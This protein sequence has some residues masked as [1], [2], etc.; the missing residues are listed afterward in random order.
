ML[1]ALL[2]TEYTTRNRVGVAL[3]RAAATATNVQRRYCKHV[4]HITQ[5][6]DFMNKDT[7]RPFT[8]AEWRGFVV[9]LHTD[10]YGVE[11]TGVQAIDWAEFVYGIQ[12]KI[13]REI[14]VELVIACP[15][16]PE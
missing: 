1:P 15:V 13:P 5:M 3:A 4:L 9:T 6:S 16:P 8:R 10:F 7:N 2:E 12:K 11:P 14:W